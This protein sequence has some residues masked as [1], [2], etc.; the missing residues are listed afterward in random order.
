MK[1]FIYKILL[2]SC[3]L[4]AYSCSDKEENESFIYPSETDKSHIYLERLNILAEFNLQ[5]QQN[6]D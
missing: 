4:V 3:L 6:S 5:M 2:C 1:T